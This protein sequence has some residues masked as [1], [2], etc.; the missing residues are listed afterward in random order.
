MAGKV[1][2]SQK[3]V[4]MP[5]R[6]PKERARVFQEVATGNGRGNTLPAL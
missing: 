6:D 5:V 1:N 2:L 3:K 4:E